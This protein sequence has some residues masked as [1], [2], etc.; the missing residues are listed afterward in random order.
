MDV[1]VL[2]DEW[3]SK[4]PGWSESK[5]VEGE[6]GEDAGVSHSDVNDVVDWLD[7]VGVSSDG[8]VKGSFAGGA[9]K[10]IRVIVAVVSGS[11]SR[12]ESS[13]NSLWSSEE[14]GSGVRDDLVFLDVG[15]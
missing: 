10:V 1:T 2:A 9:W 5:V 4:N 8:D 3:I 14:R 6:G 15:V 12:S 7:G 11:K 13:Y